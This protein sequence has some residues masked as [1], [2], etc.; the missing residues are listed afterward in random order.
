[1]ESGII[2]TVSL[3]SWKSGLDGITD[4]EVLPDFGELSLERSDIAAYRPVDETS[5]QTGDTTVF[6]L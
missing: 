5:E 3:S 4:H 6:Y 2:K 1:M